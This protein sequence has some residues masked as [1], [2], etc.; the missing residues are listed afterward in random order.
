MH[1]LAVSPNIFLK[2]NKNAIKKPP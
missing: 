2:A 1:N